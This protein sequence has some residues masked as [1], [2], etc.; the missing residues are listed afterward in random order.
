VRGAD[1]LRGHHA[2]P[3][4]VRGAEADRRRDADVRRQGH[5]RAR[6]H[7][8]QH[9]VRFDG[10]TYEI[11][12]MV[13]LATFYDPDGNPFMLAEALDGRTGR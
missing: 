13:K 1:A 3:R 7:L 4:P 5:R 8:E 9:G 11:S 2:R 10:D 6:R 12:G